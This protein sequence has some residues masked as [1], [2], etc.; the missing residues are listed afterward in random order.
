MRREAASRAWI[1]T[2]CAFA[3]TARGLVPAVTASGTV[4]DDPGDSFSPGGPGTVG[5]PVTIPAGTTHARFSLFNQN[6]S[7]PSDLDLY[8]F[9]GTTL[10]GSSGGGTSAEVVN[11]INPAAGTDYKVGPRFRRAGWTWNDVHPV[12]LAGRPA[13]RVRR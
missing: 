3:A 5:F 8:V 1:G 7:Q 10:V 13:T 11:L 2:H 9:K 4:Q 12:H 6:V